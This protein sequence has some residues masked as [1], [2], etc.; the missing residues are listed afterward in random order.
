[1]SLLSP[2]LCLPDWAGRFAR[3]RDGAVALEFGLIALPFLAILG[4]IIQTAF[5]M[6][7]S[8]SL[9]RTLQNTVRQLFTGQFQTDNSDTKDPAILLARLK[10]NMCGSGATKVT[11]TFNCADVR[12]DVSQGASFSSSAPPGAINN[13]TGDWN[14]GFG[15]NYVCAAPGSIVVVTAAVKF[16]VFFKLLNLGVVSFADGSHLLQSTAVFRTEPYQAP[17]GK[18]C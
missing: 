4:A 10:A 16:P 2:K 9:D 1:M 15:K 6:W 11:T 3:A 12:L 14:S 13:A 17:A 8:Q 5:T 18:G 7:A